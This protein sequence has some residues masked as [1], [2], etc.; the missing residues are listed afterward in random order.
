METNKIT[1]EE[2]K[3]LRELH[4]KYNNITVQ[5]GQL[6]MEQ[7]LLEQQLI[8]LKDLESSLTKECQTLQT[9]EDGY[10]KQITD[11]YGVV[12]IDLETG[13]FSTTS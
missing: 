3:Q 10:I 11:K 12:D 13:T 5:F 7:I 4:S 6:K 8:R 2:L 9:E 1:E